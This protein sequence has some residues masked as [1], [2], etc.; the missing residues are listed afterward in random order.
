[1]VIADT[2][3]SAGR[4][5]HVRTQRSPRGR[6]SVAR[7]C[8]LGVALVC[9]CYSGFAADDHAAAV[10]TDGASDGEAGEDG[11]SGADSGDDPMPPPAGFEPVPGPMR[12]LTVAQY[13][14]SIADIFGAD[15]L[16]RTPLEVD[17]T[18]E[19][20]LSIG[21]SKVGTSET[22][23]SQYRDAAFDVAAQVFER[24]DDYPLLASCQP[25]SAADACVRAFLEH[26]GTM[27]WRRPLSTAE[28]DRYAALVDAPYEEGVNP[29]LGLQYALAGLVESPNFI[30][31]VQV[32]ED[33]PASD[34]TRF[35]SV[36][37][38]SR[39]SFFLWDSTPD[40]ALLDA[41]IAGE[42]V[43]VDA[44]AEQTARML[45]SPRAEGLAARFFA[46]AWNVD[47]LDAADKNAALYPDWNEARVALYKQ[48]FERVLGRIVGE[49]ADI[50][51][52][53]DGKETLVDPALAELYG[54]PA[55]TD[56][57]A[58][59]MLDETRWGL[60]TSGAVLAANSPSDRTSPT[61]RGKFI[62]ERL[63]CKEVPPPPD[64]VDDVLPDDEPGAPPTTTRQKLEQHRD[65]P[66]CAACH[67]L[68]DPMGLTL[69]NYDAVGAWRT[70]DNGWPV[71][72]S[73]EFGGQQ[74]S[75]VADLATWLAAEPDVVECIAQNLLGYA[76][77]R[78]VG[79]DE[80]DT[81]DVLSAALTDANHDLNELVIELVTHPTFR[82]LGDAEEE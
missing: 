39:L 80:D 14:N 32:G 26:Y 21:A 42:L 70:E 81:L 23:V 1:L 54:L 43:Y 57:E 19:R 20:F 77:G 8:L 67:A 7:G 75:G 64:N 48:E 60:L 17:E 12:R 61:F 55:P 28:I 3:K 59:T 37:M 63:L 34:L 68:I 49:H 52:I 62:F 41:A 46:E 73:T 76:A 18:T 10:A 33:D 51:A 78:E 71:D 13:H 9:G 44:I 50:R 66:V 72:P 82:Y 35:T 36:E 79:S 24:R 45:Q 22:G 47:D 69:E 53:F 65:D 4:G 27:L 6:S 29:E 40:A 56:P 25:A 5:E 30:Y 11:E 58:P 2:K 15:V 38:A 31:I 74:F 16:V